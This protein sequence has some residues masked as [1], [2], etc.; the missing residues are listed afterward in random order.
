MLI[1]GQKYYIGWNTAK[2]LGSEFASYSE[3]RCEAFGIDWAVF[4]RENGE[5]LA[6]SFIDIG[7]F[8]N[9]LGD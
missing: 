9:G 3:V 1:I 5:V 7:N 8:V 4:R 2:L 6:A